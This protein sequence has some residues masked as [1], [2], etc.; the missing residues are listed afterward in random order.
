MD[1]PPLRSVDEALRRNAMT[2]RLHRRSLVAGQLTLPAVPGMIDDYVSMCETLFA[3]VGRA[4]TVEQLAQVKSVLEGQLAEAYSNSPRSNI[5]ITYDAPVGTGLNYHV[6]AE[7]WTVEG[8]YENWISTRE[9]PI[10]RRMAGGTATTLPWDGCSRSSFSRQVTP[11]RGFQRGLGLDP[12]RRSRVA[13]PPLWVA[14]VFARGEVMA[15]RDYRQ[16]D[17]EA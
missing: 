5:V 16:D 11:G 1:G 6:R 14:M 3:G 2:R 4:F 15:H 7:W 9:P 10:W 12:D 13:W 17:A 8:A